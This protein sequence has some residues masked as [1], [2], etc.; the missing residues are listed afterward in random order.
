MYK[1][2]QAVGNITIYRR[3]VRPFSD[4]QVELLANF[5]SQ[6]VIAIENTRLLVSRELR[7]SL[8]QQ[9]ATAEVLGRYFLLTRRT[10]AGVQR[11]AGERNPHLR[12]KF[13]QLAGWSRVMRSA[14]SDCMAH[15]KP[16][17]R[18]AGANP[19]FNPD[20]EAISTQLR[21]TKK[22][23]HTA[24]IV[25]D[26]NGATLAIVKLAGARTF[27]NVPMVKDDEL[28]GVIGI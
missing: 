8:A 23:I 22:I 13:R 18:N 2:D 10:G 27:L 20:R 24:D 26:G 16:L 7:E 19:S 11:D 12:R 14:W 1:D 5:A 28:I 17:P 4:K 3:E 15:Q 25:A 21:K 9:T 6:A